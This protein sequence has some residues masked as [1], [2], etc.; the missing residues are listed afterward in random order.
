MNLAEFYD[1]VKNHDWYHE[2]SD[3]GNV[4]ARGYTHMKRLRATAKLL[5][6][7]AQDILQGF[8]QHYHGPGSPV[9]PD[10][11]ERCAIPKRPA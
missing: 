11:G 2:R 6:P 7:K 9:S 4:V 10:G 8:I 3:D 5:G 1:R